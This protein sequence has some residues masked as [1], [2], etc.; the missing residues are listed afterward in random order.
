MINKKEIDNDFDLAKM[1][2]NNQKEINKV[3]INDEIFIYSLLNGKFG[4]LTDVIDKI[5]C[6]LLNNNGILKDMFNS[7]NVHDDQISINKL[8]NKLLAEQLAD[9]TSLDLFGKQIIDRYFN[10]KEN[11]NNCYELINAA[12]NGNIYAINLLYIISCNSDYYML[13]KAELSSKLNNDLSNYIQLFLSCNKNKF[14]AKIDLDD[15]FC[16]LTSPIKDDSTRDK[17]ISKLDELKLNK[18]D[19]KLS[20]MLICKLREI[21]EDRIDLHYKYDYLQ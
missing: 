13:I 12:I 14:K 15:L 21:N 9:D 11:K 17:L 2:I 18:H 3:I 7:I 1:I 19:Y 8:D 20:K 6:T 4:F 10:S 5:K 16:K